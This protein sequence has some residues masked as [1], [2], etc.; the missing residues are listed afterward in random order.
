MKW[1]LFASK[2]YSKGSEQRKKILMVIHMQQTNDCGLFSPGVLPDGKGFKPC[3]DLLTEDEAIR[4]LRLDV[5]CSS[6]PERTLKYYRDKGELIAIKVGK[7]NRYR[8]Q[9]LVDFL[10]RKSEEK[11]QRRPAI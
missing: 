4:Y 5:D 8:R 9:D 10:A 3:P 1:Q 7:K 11:Q 6:E 2:K